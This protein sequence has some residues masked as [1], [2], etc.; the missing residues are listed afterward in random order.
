MF[1]FSFNFLIPKLER[2]LLNSAGAAIF[3]GCLLS[4]IIIIVYIIIIIVCYT[5][6]MDII[7]VQKNIHMKLQSN[8][9]DVC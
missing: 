5:M 6:Y 8:D 1:F 2:F 4:V 9:H 3:S 7:Q